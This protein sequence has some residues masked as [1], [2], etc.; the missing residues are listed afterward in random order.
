MTLTVNAL[1]LRRLTHKNSQ[2]Q[3]SH[4]HSSAEG[5]VCTAASLWTAL[6]CSMLRMK[7]AQPVRLSVPKHLL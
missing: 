4:Q 5:F 7:C 1:H 2:T 3:P 6:Q